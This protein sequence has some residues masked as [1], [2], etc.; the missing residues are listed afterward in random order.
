MNNQANYVDAEYF[1]QQESQELNCINP[2]TM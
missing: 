1:C 2:M